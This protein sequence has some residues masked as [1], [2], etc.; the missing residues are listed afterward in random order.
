TLVTVT[1]VTVTLAVALLATLA[2]GAVAGGVVTPAALAAL[3]AA[4]PV[5]LAL[6]PPGALSGTVGGLACLGCGR[7][8]SELA[9]GAV[10]LGTLSGG[11]LS[12]ST[13]SRGTLSR[14][15]GLRCVAG[16]AS[17]CLTR[18]RGRFLRRT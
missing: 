9:V 4:L 7:G 1:L 10:G 5:L 17:P 2:G 12:G 6:G 3:A 18:G 11:A 14:G 16:P 13:L 8:E 15:I